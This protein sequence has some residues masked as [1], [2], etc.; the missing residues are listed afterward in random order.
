MLF[1][2]LSRCDLEPDVKTKVPMVLDK[3]TLLI[4]ADGGFWLKV[5]TRKQASSI[6][7]CLLNK[8]T[9]KA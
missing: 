6:V 1:Y 9:V 7:S 4:T 3:K 5:R 8:E 2:M